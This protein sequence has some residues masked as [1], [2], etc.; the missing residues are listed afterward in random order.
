ML[1]QLWLRSINNSGKF[2]GALSFPWKL[3]LKIAHALNHL[4]IFQR[5]GDKNKHSLCISGLFYWGNLL[6]KCHEG[7]QY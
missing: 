1:N 5:E 2:R 7:I 3:S 6:R 4:M